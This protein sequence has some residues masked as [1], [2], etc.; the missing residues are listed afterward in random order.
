MIG[1]DDFALRRGHRYATIITDAETGR[2]VAVLPGREAATLESWLRDHPG[3]ESCAGTAPPPTPRPS[4]VLCPTRRRSATDGTCGAISATRSCWRSEHTPAAGPPSIHPAPAECTNRAPANAGTRWPLSAHRLPSSRVS[5]AVAS[6]PM[7]STGC[8]RTV[9]SARAA[10]IRRPGHWGSGDAS[11][12]GHFADRDQQPFQSRRWQCVL[13]GVMPLAFPGDLD[14]SLTIEEHAA[15]TVGNAQAKALLW[16]RASPIPVLTDDLGL[17]INALDGRPGAFMKT[18]G[19]QIPESVTEA[20][21]LAV[22]D[23]A[24]RGLTD[25]T[26]YLETSIAAATPTGRFGHRTL[27]QHGWIDKMRT[28]NPHTR[29]PLLE[30]VFVFED[31]GT[32]WRDMTA[33]QQREVDERLRREAIGLLR[34][35]CP[36]AIPA[37]IGNPNSSNDDGRQRAG[38]GAQPCQ[39]DERRTGTGA[40]MKYIPPASPC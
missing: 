36:Q 29:G 21:R 32:F 17:F 8:S 24:V 15:T 12:A 33:C 39:T 3:V 19:G 10:V 9:A 13:R 34:S 30:D 4:A 1:V 37:L 26:C 31:Y 6:P 38:G 16:C 40:Q 25:T 35:L 23:A 7:S 22:L 20:E 5:W 28:S 11:A 18:W 14:M 27:R 2:R